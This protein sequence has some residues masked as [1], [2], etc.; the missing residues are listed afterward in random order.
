M[1]QYGNAVWLYFLDALDEEFFVGFSSL[2]VTKWPIPPPDGQRREVGF[3]PMLAVASRFQ[4]KPSCG[5]GKHY[6]ETIMEH[7]T[8][9][10]RERGYKELCLFVH[11]DNTR[12]IRLYNRHGFRIVETR[13]DKGLLK[14]LRL[15]D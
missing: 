6:I 8:E 10:A 1:E 15:L 13:N 12:A 2:G 11:A 14:M 7:V 5:G 4:G 3:I 9:Q